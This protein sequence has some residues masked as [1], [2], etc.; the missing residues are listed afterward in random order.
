MFQRAFLNSSLYILF[1][2]YF[3]CAFWNAF[4][5]QLYSS[6][7]L[8]YE[9]GS[10]PFI[11]IS[12]MCRLSGGLRGGRLLGILTTE[13]DDETPGPPVPSCSMLFPIC[14]LISREHFHLLFLDDSFKFHLHHQTCKFF[15]SVEGRVRMTSL[16]FV[17][18]GG[19]HLIDRK[20]CTKNESFSL[21]LTQLSLSYAKGLDFNLKEL[22]IISAVLPF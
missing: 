14:F 11:S 18:R 16:S 13:S 2:L 9:E 7:C 15:C 17:C 19:G 3:I 1:L 22:A 12:Q 10:T 21:L 5:T 4:P 8:R 20:I 6:Y